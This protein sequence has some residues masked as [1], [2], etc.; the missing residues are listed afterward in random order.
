VAAVAA[1]AEG[2]A[3]CS[4][5][6]GTKAL[7]DIADPPVAAASLTVCLSSIQART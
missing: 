2:K 6:V 1:V 5:V 7:A 3:S 4:T